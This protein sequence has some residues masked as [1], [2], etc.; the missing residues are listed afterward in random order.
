MKWFKLYSEF[1]NDPRLRTFTKAQRYDLICLM[2]FANTSSVRG[3]LIFEDEDIAATIDMTEEEWVGFRD[4][5]IRKSILV[6]ENGRL[7][8]TDWAALQA[9]KPSDEP[10]RVRERV[11]R[12]RNNRAGVT[13]ESV[14]DEASCEL[15]VDETHCNALQTPTDK[16]RSEETRSEENRIFKK[17]LGRSAPDG[18]NSPP[19]LIKF[20]KPSVE[21]IRTYFKH[22][23]YDDGAEAFFDYWEI[24]GWKSKRG[25]VCDWRAAV[26]HWNRM[27]RK[28][29]GGYKPAWSKSSSDGLPEVMFKPHTPKVRAVPAGWLE[30]EP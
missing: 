13:S 15:E 26:R 28:F 12:H 8:F 27:E 24:F 16:I 2:C 19:L 29:A 20:V 10:E 5:L 9:V 1:G 25:E 22:M 3:S 14:S 18:A 23:R 30:S 4:K 7:T 6:I 17:E 11:T 21:E